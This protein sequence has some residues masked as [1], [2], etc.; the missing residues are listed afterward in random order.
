MLSP[1]SGRAQSFSTVSEYPCLVAA[2]PIAAFAALLPSRSRGPLL[3]IATY[4]LY[5]ATLAYPRCT[6]HL[7][8]RTGVCSGNEPEAEKIHARRRKYRVISPS[9]CSFTIRSSLVFLLSLL[10]LLFKKRKRKNRRLGPS[11]ESGLSCPQILVFILRT[12]AKLYGN[13]CFRQNPLGH[14]RATRLL[15]I[16]VIFMHACSS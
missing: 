6:L 9:Q 8:R 12:V 3:R 5:L 10:L 15:L 1:R 13:R 7:L 4:I 11:R 14:N 2:R 16:L